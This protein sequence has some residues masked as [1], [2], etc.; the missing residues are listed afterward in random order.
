[1]GVGYLCAPSQPIQWDEGSI[2]YVTGEE[3][4]NGC[5]YPLR[6]TYSHSLALHCSSACVGRGQALNRSSVPIIDS[7]ARYQQQA[8]RS[9]GRPG[10][11]DLDLVLGL[12]GWAMQTSAPPGW[13]GGRGGGKRAVWPRRVAMD[14]E[15]EVGRSRKE[16]EGRAARAQASQVL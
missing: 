16:K 11:P 10:H 14:A 5:L 2:R 7:C 13:A 4:R 6:L 9:P 1:M 12:G 3:R 8:Q 15:V